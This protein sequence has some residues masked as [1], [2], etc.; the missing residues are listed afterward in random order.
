MPCRLNTPAG[1]RA[2]LCQ[3]Q[4]AD[5]REEEEERKKET[6]RNPLSSSPLHVEGTVHHAGKRHKS[7]G[8][9]GGTE[10]VLGATW[11]PPA[12]CSHRHGVQ[13]GPKTKTQ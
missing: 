10:E 3:I 13:R 6:A 2:A 9:E 1:S 11:K 12:S 4:H 8:W 5:G 7:L